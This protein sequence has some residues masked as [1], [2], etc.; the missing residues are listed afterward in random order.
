MVDAASCRVP[1]KAAGCRFH[2]VTRQ[3]AIL[4]HAV[5]LNGMVIFAITGMAAIRACSLIGSRDFRMLQ[6]L[7]ERQ[8]RSAF[9]SANVACL[10]VRSPCAK[11]SQP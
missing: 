4:N 2:D 3:E 10:G 11:G 7:P 8:G 1:G 6:D 5:F 9:S